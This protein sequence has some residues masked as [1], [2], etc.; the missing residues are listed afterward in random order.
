MAKKT[1]DIDALLEK[2]RKNNGEDSIMR[3]DGPPQR[4]DV[5]PSGCLSLDVALGIGGY[6]R[7]R[8]IEIY[9]PESAGKS[10]LTLHAIA[11]V[12]KLGGLAAFIDAEHALDPIY[13]QKL[14][15]DTS[16]VLISQPSSGEQ[17]LKIAEE[18]VDS[19]M[20]DLIVI[21]SV[22]A[23]TPQAELD[24]DIGD[25]HVGL[26][27][28]LMGQAMRML[29]GKVSK[30]AATLIF[31]NQLRLKIGVLYGSPETTTGGQALKFYSSVRID[32]RKREKTKDKDGEDDGNRTVFKVVK[33]K[34]AVPF[35][36]ADVEI[37][38][39]VGIDRT[40]DILTCAVNRGLVEKAG[41]WYS[42]GGVKLGMGFN[43]VAEKLRG[44]P[45]LLGDIE[46]RVRKEL[47][48]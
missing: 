17:A 15:V 48:P 35:R 20:V 6:P 42:Y 40:G 5:I 30:N 27:A 7:G 16:K 33:N 18:L 9:G 46:Q 43:T 3:L 22:A 44:D 25:S 12:Q 38:W 41:N 13:A 14:G 39:G 11:E 21:D 2:I 31:I 28:R 45:K 26:H 36:E 37:K 34:L 29:A 4:V 10:T 47:L 19:K 8:I 1:D 23:L 24:G 32:V